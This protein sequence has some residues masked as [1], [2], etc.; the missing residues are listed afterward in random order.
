MEAV[1]ERILGWVAIA[2]AERESNSA[3]DAGTLCAYHVI[4]LNPEIAMACQQDTRLQRVLGA[5]DLVVPDGVGILWAARWRGQR[6]PERVTGIDL[7]ERLAARAAQHGHRLFLLG[8]RPGVA[9]EAAA[10]LA[11]RYPG[12]VVAGTHGGSPNPCDDAETLARIAGARP[13]ILLV[14]YGAPAQ[15]W[16]IAR[17][18]TQVGVPVVIGVGGALDLLAGRVPRAPQWMRRVGM[19]W[20]Y[21]LLREPWRARRMLALPRF[22]WAV[23]WGR[24]PTMATPLLPSPVVGTDDGAGPGQ[25][26]QARLGESGGGPS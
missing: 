18:R 22:G 1:V 4:T 11:R 17:L 3:D 23:L 24:E 6:L 8:A 13:D 12:L 20:L 5:A 15:E 16:W 26:P 25:T 2:H 7:A 10:R 14:A 19:E 21:R 9:E